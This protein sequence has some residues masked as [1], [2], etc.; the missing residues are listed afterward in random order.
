M[1]IDQVKKNSSPLNQWDEEEKSSVK[2]HRVHQWDGVI[3]RFEVP[4][5]LLILPNVVKS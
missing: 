2:R 4:M 5:F 3:D 1:T